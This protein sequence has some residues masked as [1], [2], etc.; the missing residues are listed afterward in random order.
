MILIALII[1]VFAGCSISLFIIAKC[2]AH[3]NDYGNAKGE[4]DDFT[5]APLHVIRKEDRIKKPRF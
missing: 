3:S 1:G 5:R 4:F 2:V